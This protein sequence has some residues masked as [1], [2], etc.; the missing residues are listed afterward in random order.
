MVFSARPGTVRE[1]IHVGLTRP[2]PLDVKRTA[3]FTALTDRI[4][5]LIEHEVQRAAASNE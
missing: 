2:R 1:E 3:E 5:R 4:W